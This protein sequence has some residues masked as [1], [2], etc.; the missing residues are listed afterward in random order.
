MR[1]EEHLK[2]R[3]IVD[4]PITYKFYRVID[5][6]P[7][8]SWLGEYTDRAIVPYF[9]LIARVLVIR[10]YEDEVPIG[11]EDEPEYS[12]VDKY[13]AFERCTIVGRKD[14]RQVTDYNPEDHMRRSGQYRYI[15]KF[16]NIPKDDKDLDAVRACLWDAERLDA[17]SNGDWQMTGICCRVFVDVELDGEPC[18][19]PLLISGDWQFSLWGVE[20][21]A[22]KAYLDEVC[23]DLMSEAKGDLRQLAVD[24]AEIAGQELNRCNTVIRYLASLPHP[25]QNG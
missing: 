25:L 5:E 4:G 21:D 16:Q 2:D 9:D 7:D 3:D 22:D 17:Y 10:E 11:T 19:D 6:N 18:D 20:S 1:D 8:L 15:G 24:A 23:G 12:M 14:A 13:V